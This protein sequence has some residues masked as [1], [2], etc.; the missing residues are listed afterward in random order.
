MALW[1]EQ[2]SAAEELRRAIDCLSSNAELKGV[3]PATVEA[4]AAGAVHFSLPAGD[5]LFESGS[6][7]DGV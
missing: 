6:M 5:L 7:P 3:A 2:S 4:L 1:E